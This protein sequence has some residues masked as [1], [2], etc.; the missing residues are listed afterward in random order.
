MAI[1]DGRDILRVRVFRLLKELREYVRSE[2]GYAGRVYGFAPS[3]DTWTASGRRGREFVEVCL[4]E[5]HL[6]PETIAHEAMHV[7]ASWARRHGIDT[8]RLQW[9]KGILVSFEEEQLCEIH[10][11]II[12]GIHKG[13]RQAELID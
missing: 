12:H 2:W 11:Q 13:L 5:K 3:Y 8:A 1:N 9:S 7:M 6:E 10:S 4:C